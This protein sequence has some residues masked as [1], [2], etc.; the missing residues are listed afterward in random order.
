MKSHGVQAIRYT[1]GGTV[2]KKSRAARC[3]CSKMGVFQ[4]VGENV[5]RVA[6]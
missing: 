4:V 3:G 1:V 2:F 6:F 5:V